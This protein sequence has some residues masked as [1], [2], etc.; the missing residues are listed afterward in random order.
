MTNVL[1]M[2]LHSE[3]E[4]KS[5][6]TTLPLVGFTITFVQFRVLMAVTASLRS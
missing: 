4:A 2:P 5:Q 6:D 3:L 1:T